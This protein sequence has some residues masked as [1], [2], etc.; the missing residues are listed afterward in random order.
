MP[1]PTGWKPLSY[2]TIAKIC[3]RLVLGDAP[4]TVAKAAGASRATVM[5]L[6]KI[7]LA[8]GAAPN[9]QELPIETDRLIFELFR[10]TSLTD[11]GIAKK[12]GLRAKNLSP[13]RRR[14]SRYYEQL[15]S[16]GLT[17]PL[18][19][20]GS[21]FQHLHPCPYRQ[22]GTRAS[23]GSDDKGDAVKAL[24]A[25]KPRAEIGKAFN[26]SMRS[27]E[28]F[29]RRLSPDQR[30]QRAANLKALRLQAV[31]SRK[32]RK[33]SDGLFARLDTCLSR[34]L[35]PETRAET[36]QTMALDILSGAIAEEQAIKQ[37]R[38]YTN[39]AYRNQGDPWRNVSIDADYNG[40]SLGDLLEDESALEAYEQLDDALL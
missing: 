34:S 27:I 40:L 16:Q 31:L 37:L 35:D 17:V 24:I 15:R 26:Y 6:K 10:T 28:K 2:T 36:L 18:C 13:I 30:K 1:R 7:L 29:V 5:H 14:R 11:Y 3:G 23:V 21:E 25:G 20:C 22:A 12:L 39:R 32:A 19:K 33:R 4:S 8:M 38:S 9:A